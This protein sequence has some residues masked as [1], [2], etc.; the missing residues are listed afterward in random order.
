[1]LTRI[2]IAERLSVRSGLPFNQALEACLAIEA[3]M[4]EALRGKAKE[5]WQRSPKSKKPSRFAN[6]AFFY[7]GFA[8]IDMWANKGLIGKNIIGD[9]V[10][11]INFFVAYDFDRLLNP[12]LKPMTKHARNHIT[13]EK[14][15][16]GIL[17][18]RERKKK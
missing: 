12:S 16:L 3:A 2:D 1:M 17:K 5:I 7:T 4:A 14:I 11:N 8:R 9:A 10:M 6:S 13:N 18:G 15:R